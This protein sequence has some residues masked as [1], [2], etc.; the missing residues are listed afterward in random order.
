MAKVWRVTYPLRP[1]LEVST[2]LADYPH[3]GVH[4][5]YVGGKLATI[6]HELS[7]EDG[8]SVC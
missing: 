6:K 8:A 3:L 5:E 2:T 7:V 4:F 1:Q